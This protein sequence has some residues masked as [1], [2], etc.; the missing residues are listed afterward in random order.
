MAGR[1]DRALSS[2]LSPAGSALRVPIAQASTVRGRFDRI[3]FD[4]W[5]CGHSR[6]S[7]MSQFRYRAFIS[8]SHADRGWGDWLHKALETWSVP[9]RLVGRQTAAGTIPRRLAPIFRDRDELPS[10][11]DL[12][13]KV[14]EALA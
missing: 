10:A 8:Y 13:S 9:E 12:G 6:S 7:S 1:V 4:Q 14:K 3:R 5:K 11:T 2:V